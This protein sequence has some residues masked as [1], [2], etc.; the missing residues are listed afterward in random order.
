M[1]INV[2]VKPS[3]LLGSCCFLRRNY[4]VVEVNCS[5]VMAGM[6]RHLSDINT[7]N[8]YEIAAQGRNDERILINFFPE[9][10]S[11]WVVIGY[12]DHFS[13]FAARHTYTYLCGVF[14]DHL[15]VMPRFKSFGTVFFFVL[16]IF[17]FAVPV[18]GSQQGI[19]DVF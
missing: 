9:Y 11:G 2:R 10:I 1:A 5:D 15:R 17:Y 3:H 16:V 14:P 13:A 7:N 12:N 6:T 19:I 8:N 18:F 4:E